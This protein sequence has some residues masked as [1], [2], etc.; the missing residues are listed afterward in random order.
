MTS[1]RKETFWLVKSEILQQLASD[2]S[3]EAIELFRQ[4]LHDK[5]ASVRKTA[6]QVLNPVPDLLQSTVEGLLYDSSY[7]NVQ[8]ALE[9]LCVSFPKNQEHYLDITR[10]MEGWRGKNIRM[11]W[12]E[13]AIRNGKVEYLPEMIAYCGPK[14]E[15]ETRMNAF[16]ALKRLK[17]T[18]PEVSGYARDASKHWNYK[19]SGVAREYVKFSEQISQ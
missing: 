15:F 5:D 7:L 3:P 2:Q 4:A 11:S 18:S 9:A 16:T 8:F 13:I 19:L 12:L 17:F 1:F 6:L 14:Y 10:D